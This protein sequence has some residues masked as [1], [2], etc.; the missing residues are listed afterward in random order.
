[1]LNI[2]DVKGKD[3]RNPKTNIV[4]TFNGFVYTYRP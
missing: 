1:M 3:V 2:I 4:N